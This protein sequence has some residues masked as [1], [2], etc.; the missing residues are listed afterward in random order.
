[1]C[2]KYCLFAL[3]RRHRTIASM[4]IVMGQTKRAWVLVEPS[5]PADAGTYFW[6]H[7]QAWKDLDHVVLTP[8]L[9]DR[10][11]SAEVLTSLEGHDFLTPGKR[12]PRGR[13]FASDHLPVVCKMHYQ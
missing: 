6:S 4:E 2:S 5:R 10:V 11:Q 8:E 3:D 9:A 13:A 1:M 12:V 7:A